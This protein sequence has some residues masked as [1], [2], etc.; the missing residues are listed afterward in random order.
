MSF[1]LKIDFRGVKLLQKRMKELKTLEVETGFF[2]ESQYGSENDNLPVA[3][4]AWMQ[5]KG[6]DEYPA[7]PFFD[8]TVEDAMVQFHLGRAL[9]EAVKAAL[10]P[11]GN[12]RKALIKAGNILKDEVEVSIEDYPGSNSLSWAAYKGKN[13]PLSFTD[14]MLNSVKVKIKE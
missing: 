14:T 1:D 2:P 12:V 10:L 3:A 5:Q 13:D 11:R 4:V 9:T 7:R 6:A 8:N